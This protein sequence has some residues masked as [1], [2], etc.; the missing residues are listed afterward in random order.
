MLI[1]E[2]FWW[3][4]PRPSQFVRAIEGDLL[5]GKNVLVALPAHAPSGLRRAMERQVKAGELYSFREIDSKNGPGAAADSPARIVAHALRVC[6]LETEVSAESIATAGGVGETV[7]WVGG[8]DDSTWPRWR[9]FAVKYE[10][11]CRN[12]PPYE[13]LL[14]VLPVVGLSANLF[15]RENLTLSVRMWRGVVERLDMLLFVSHVINRGACH[16]LLQQTAIATVTELAGTDPSVAEFM[17]VRPL[18]SQLDPLPALRDFGIA[19]GWEEQTWRAC[20]GDDDVGWCRGV[21]DELDGSRWL[22]S[23]AVALVSDL[24]TLRRRL[25]A[26][27]VG[28]LFPFLEHRRLSFVAAHRALLSLPVVT[29]WEQ[30]DDAESLE[31]SHL[32]FQLKHRISPA[33]FARIELCRRMRN[34]LAHLRPLGAND[35]LSEEFEKILA[36][37]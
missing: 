30:I 22:H 27:Q 5:A 6:G 21:A 20:G 10:F 24:A 4:L 37:V 36:N 34:E 1:N 18:E 32:A 15:P 7:L 3:S 12:V 35:L 26:A 8:I 13:R 19:R 23:G 11:A 17:A 16:P 28:I 25:W 33:C 14:F 29:P 31:L 9:D 2:K